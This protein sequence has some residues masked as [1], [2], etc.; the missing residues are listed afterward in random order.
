MPR[1]P[2]PTHLRVL[3][4]NPQRRPLRR[5]PEPA[6]LPEPPEPPSF[7]VGFAAEEWSRVVNELHVL[8][9]L[10]RIDLMLLGAYCT[11]FA[12][13]RQAV[14]ALATMATKDALSRGLLVRTKDGARRN[15]LVKVA[16]DASLLMLRFAGELGLGAVARARLAAG[17]QPPE[18]SSKFGNLLACC[19][20]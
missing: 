1:Y 14:E 12:V 20:C 6:A 17:W 5:E 11:N 18:R 15:P 3:Q 4:G 19:F 2:T 10:R 13:W 16:G 8:G 9:L 7:I